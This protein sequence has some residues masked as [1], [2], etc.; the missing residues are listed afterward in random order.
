MTGTLEFATYCSVVSGIGRYIGAP[1][2]LGVKVGPFAREMLAVCGIELAINASSAWGVP[3]TEPRTTDAGV[4]LGGICLKAAGRA[5]LAT[6]VHGPL[7]P[8]A[9]YQRPEI[10]T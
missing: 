5:V 8:G 10:S 1:S 9:R 6:K 3:A 2:K 7:S 4:P